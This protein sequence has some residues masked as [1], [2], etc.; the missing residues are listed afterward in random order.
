M[1]AKLL[2]RIWRARSSFASS[3]G[4]NV[5][6]ITGLSLPVLLGIAGL[7]VEGAAWYTER[8]AMQ[9]AA[10]AA[11][12]AAASNASTNYQAEARAVTA[13]L[14]F[15]NGTANTTVTAA[16]AVTCPSGASGCYSVTVTRDVPLV[17]SRVVGY[18]GSVT[19][20]G[21]PAIRLT[22]TAIATQAMVPREYCILAL[23]DG[24]GT[25]AVDFLSNGGPH[26]DLAGCSVASN[27]SMT[28]NGH[29]L[30]ADFGDAAGTNNGCGN[31]Q[32]SNMPT[33]PDNYSGLASNIPSNP[34]GSYPGVTWAGGTRNLTG[35]TTICGTLTLSGDVTLTGSG[36]IVIYN[37]NLE[38]YG[39]DLATATGASATIVFAG[40]N[41]GSISHRISEGRPGNQGNYISI[42]APT[43]GPWA[44]IAVYQAPNLTTNV[45]M[46][47][48]GNN[49]TFKFT[50]VV[51]LPKASLT[52]SGA[53]NK[54]DGGEN[55]TVLVVKSIRINGTAAIANTTNGCP[56]A[57]VTMPAGSVAGRGR[58]VD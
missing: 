6:L 27:S 41:S 38:L 23:G 12:V 31:V 48:A 15:T 26:A 25:S 21:A 32:N 19:V 9:N 28:C 57:G 56:A 1:L 49:P 45:D 51:Y 8:R 16:N 47:F 33:V 18:T 55:C 58:L 10:D 22:T 5:L 44:G 24:S 7:G 34:C 36:V 2:A 35:T 50:G 54:A 30:N 20:G 40:T 46:E 29:N 14:G 3:E 17:F 52:F 13:R 11:V 4:G 53:I 37:G 42:K 39:N 43:T